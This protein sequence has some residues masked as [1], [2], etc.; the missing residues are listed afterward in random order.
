MDNSPLVIPRDRFSTGLPGRR[1]P[2]SSAR[3]AADRPWGM[4]RAL[5]PNPTVTARHERPTENRVVSKPTQV[6]NDGKIETD[7]VTETQ[8]D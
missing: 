5:T 6:Q 7:T 1:V 8:T 3:P 2:L 4:D